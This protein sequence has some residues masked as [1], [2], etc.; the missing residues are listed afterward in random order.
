MGCSLL[1]G[2]DFGCERPSFTN[3]VNDN[4]LT[5]NRKFD[6]M[7]PAHINPQE[8]IVSGIAEQL[9][10]WLIENN[11]IKITHHQTEKYDFINTL[12]SQYT[13]EVDFKFFE[14]PRRFK[15]K[16]II[17]KKNKK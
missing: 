1:D 11:Y 15:K 6:I 13:G 8:Y 12:T 16:I 3:N 17:E 2:L 7:L 14:V 5:F 9:A 10:K 4:Y